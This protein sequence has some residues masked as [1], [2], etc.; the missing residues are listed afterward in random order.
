MTEPTADRLSE[1]DLAQAV[2]YV[3]GELTEQEAFAFEERLVDEP[4]LAQAVDDLWLVDELA[5]RAQV[6]V[7]R[8]AWWRRSGPRATMVTLLATAA[9]VLVM[10]QRPMSGPG[11]LRVGVLDFDYAAAGIPDPPLDVR[12]EAAGGDL[13]EWLEEYRAAEQDAAAEALDRPNSSLP[14][15]LF[16]AVECA[17]DCTVIVVASVQGQW[18]RLFPENV[19]SGSARLGAGVHVLPKSGYEI[20][21]GTIGSIALESK[22]FALPTSGVDTVIVGSTT[23]LL[24]ADGLLAIDEVIAGGGGEPAVVEALGQLGLVVSTVL[25]NDG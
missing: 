14:S 23:S 8:H 4:A 16:L 10:L 20:R 25:R 22:G 15:R 12:G 24:D 1:D 5:G 7:G 2:A 3:D 11:P 9:A 19:D 13:Y 6:A 21:E 17:E 18:Q